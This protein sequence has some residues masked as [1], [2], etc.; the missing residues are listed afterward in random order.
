MANFA[1]LKVNGNITLFLAGVLIPP[2]KRIQNTAELKSNLPAFYTV[3]LLGY[4][5]GHKHTSSFANC[6]DPY[7]RFSFDLL[8]VLHFASDGHDNVVPNDDSKALRGY[9]NFACW[10]VL[11]YCIGAG[12]TILTM[13]FGIGSI[14][15]SWKIKLIS[16][17]SALVCCNPN[18]SNSIDTDGSVVVIDISH[19]RIN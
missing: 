19:C 14:V 5:Q 11:V 8:S 7:I 12:A 9:R 15:F 18:L 10:F 4:C 6:S 16:F 3:G 17:I 1:E 13:I 2:T